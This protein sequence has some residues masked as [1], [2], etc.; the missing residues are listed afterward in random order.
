[1]SF[2]TGISAMQQSLGGTVKRSQYISGLRVTGLMNI[3]A[4]IYG[5]F[6]FYSTVSSASLVNLTGVKKR[7]PF[8]LFALMLLVLGCFVPAVKLLTMIPVPVRNAVM[9]I[10][11]TQMLGFGLKDL[12][13]TSLDRRQVLVIGIPILISVGISN[14]PAQALN[15]I[16]EYA[17][18]VLGNG[19]LMGTLLCIL[20][21]HVIISKTGRSDTEG[22]IQDSL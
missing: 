1:P 4:G 9:L 16:P 8:L 20:L 17:R 10:S 12:L 21:E 3:I 18:L 7:A 13:R 2:M 6:G 19:F 15:D 11:F 5:I 14:L 22:Q